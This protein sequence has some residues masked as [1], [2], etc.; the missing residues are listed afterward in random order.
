MKRPLRILLGIA[1]AVI[2]TL[3]SMPTARADII[4][5]PGNHPQPDEQNVLLKD[6][7]TGA[8]VTGVTNKTG[9]E[10]VFNSRPSS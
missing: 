10:V 5:T 6:G 2:M 8:T 7:T 1:V 9:E 4:F 3:T